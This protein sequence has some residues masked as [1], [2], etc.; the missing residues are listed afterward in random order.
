[1]LEPS[2]R[3]SPTVETVGAQ[4]VLDPRWGAA[5]NAGLPPKKKQDKPIRLS[6]YRLAGVVSYRYTRKE[7]VQT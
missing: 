2:C 4:L 7:V 1:M 5:A 3:F 6:E